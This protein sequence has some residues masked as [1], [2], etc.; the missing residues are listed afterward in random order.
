MKRLREMIEHD[1]DVAHDELGFRNLER[2]R[3]LRKMNGIAAR[4]ELIRKKAYAGSGE[5]D[6]L[7]RKRV[8]R[9]DPFERIQN[10]LRPERSAPAALDDRDARIVLHDMERLLEHQDGIAVRP[11]GERSGLENRLRAEL[12]RER[13]RRKAFPGEGEV[14]IIGSSRHKQSLVK[15]IRKRKGNKKKTP[16]IGVSSL[17]RIRQ[18]QNRRLRLKGPPPPVVVASDCIC[19]LHAV[20]I[21][22]GKTNGKR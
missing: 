10:V 22:K 8:L 13:K 11:V 6:C 5:G 19:D 17:P 3:L 16:E 18:P 4:A 7:R 2:I 12:L 20:K 15:I 9:G 14:N 21:D 1:V